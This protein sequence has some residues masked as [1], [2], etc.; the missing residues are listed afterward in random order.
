[1]K[2]ATG[3]IGI[4]LSLLV[5]VQACAIFAGS[6]MAE[7]QP[8]GEAGAVGLLVGG[9]LFLGGAFAF[10][11]PAVSMVIFA[12]GGLLAVA[13]SGT[14]A[15]MWIWGLVSFALAIMSFFAWRSARKARKGSEQAKAAS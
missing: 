2:L 15:D 3:L 7:D 5:M 13:I 8:L 10:G 1:M 14:F 11:L 6:S 9:L 4:F 12:I